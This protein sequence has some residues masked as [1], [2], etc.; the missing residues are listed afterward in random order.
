MDGGKI[1]NK[2]YEQLIY[3]HMM[4]KVI[5]NNEYAEISKYNYKSK[6]IKEDGSL[7]VKRYL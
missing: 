1:N 6:F 2:I 5:R 4:M 7:D 3:N